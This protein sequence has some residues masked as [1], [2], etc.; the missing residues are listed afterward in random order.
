M[1]TTFFKTPRDC[2]QRLFP[3]EDGSSEINI[4]FRKTSINQLNYNNYETHY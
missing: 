4:A 3:K 2:I 1:K